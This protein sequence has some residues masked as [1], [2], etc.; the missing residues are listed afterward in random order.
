MLNN[1]KNLWIERDGIIK[2]VVY[3]KLVRYKNDFV[4]NSEFDLNFGLKIFKFYF[5]VYL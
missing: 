4:Y 5:S 3:K 1:L 2:V